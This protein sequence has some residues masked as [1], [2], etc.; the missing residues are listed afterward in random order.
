MGMSGS[1]SAKFGLTNDGLAQRVTRFLRKVY[2]AKTADRVA[3]DT[4]ISV[5]TVQK[6]LQ[7]VAKPNGYAM[8]LMVNAYGPDFLAEVT[9]RPPDWLCRTRRAEQQADLE[10]EQTRIAA[11]LEAFR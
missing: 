9:P 5:N 11:A 10:A 2:P 7:G 1:E 4:G 3:Y 8:I 6:W